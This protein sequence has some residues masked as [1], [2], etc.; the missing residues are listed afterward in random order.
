MPTIDGTEYEKGDLIGQVNYQDPVTMAR[1][2]FMM[3]SEDF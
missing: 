2:L 3:L 1:N